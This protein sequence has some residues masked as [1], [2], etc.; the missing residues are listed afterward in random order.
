M[1]MWFEIRRCIGGSVRVYRSRLEN[2]LRHFDVT[3][4][5][6]LYLSP[7]LSCRSA[8]GRLNDQPHRGSACFGHDIFEALELPG[9]RTICVDGSESLGTPGMGLRSGG[10][11]KFKK[12]CEK[13]NE[14]TKYRIHGR[15]TRPWVC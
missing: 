10:A 14:A 5:R 4:V 8:L 7:T 6:P 1:Y 2:Q 13:M 15:S 11:R 3:H 9:Q 12:A